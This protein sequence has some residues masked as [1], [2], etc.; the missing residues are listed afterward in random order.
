MTQTNPLGIE[1]QDRMYLVKEVAKMF[2]VTDLTVRLWITRGLKGHKLQAIKMGK[3]W[4]VS[5]QALVE[6]ANVINE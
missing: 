2:Q 1:L 3:S 5:L 6:W 4:Q